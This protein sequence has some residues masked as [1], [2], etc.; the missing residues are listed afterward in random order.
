MVENTSNV[1]H[2]FKR[3]NKSKKGELEDTLC[4]IKNN[5]RQK[6]HTPN[7]ESI[8]HQHESS[9]HQGGINI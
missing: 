5:K 8:S 6:H 3:G 9:K 2:G 7:N 4:D 1:D